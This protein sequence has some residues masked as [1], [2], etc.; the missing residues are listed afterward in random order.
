MTAAVLV[1]LAAPAGAQWIN[2]PTPGIPRTKDG[3]PNLTARAPRA[4]D[5][6]PDLSGM[7]NINGIGTVTN[8]TDVEMLPAAQALFKKRLETYSNDD[9]G[10]ACLPEGPRAGIAG[11]DPLRIIQ[12][13]AMVAILYEPGTFRLI[14][15]DGR[16]LPKDMNPTWMGYSIGRWDG[17]T[18]VVTTAGY[19]DR[20]WLDFIGHPHSDALR[21]TERFRRTDFGHMQLEMTFDDP[22]TYV[23]PFTIKL[24]VSFVA[25]DDLI[26]YVCL[27]N[28]RDRGKLVG[29]IA[30]EK[31]SE[32]K[33]PANVLAEYVGKYD[34]GPLGSWTMSIVGGELAVEVSDGGGRQPMFARTDNVFVFPGIGGTLTFVKEKNAV[35]H[36]V[37]T[38]VEGDLRAN[39]K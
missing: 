19:N 1:L 6:K 3:K 38:T 36:F 23:R 26:E 17:D 34:V 28:E 21:V 29:R 5:G 32:K 37:L 2:Y 13:P 16:P 39:R 27:E 25:D 12:T 24:N 33:V 31:T 14:Y 4:A 7:W 30:D 9:P 8:I 10:I 20:S 15:T 18:F 22:K 11:L 35:T